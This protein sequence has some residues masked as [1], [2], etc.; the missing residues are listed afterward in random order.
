MVSLVS[1]GDPYK[2][3]LLNKKGLNQ[4]VSVQILTDQ[5]KL[6]KDRHEMI[7]ENAGTVIGVAVAVATLALFIIGTIVAPYLST[8]EFTYLM[9]SATIVPWLLAGAAAGGITY[10][11]GMLIRNYK[12]DKISKL[13]L[14]LQNTYEKDAQ[15]EK[16][17]IIAMLKKCYDVQKIKLLNKMNFEQLLDAKLA[18]GNKK[19]NKFLDQKDAGGKKFILTKEEHQLIRFIQTLSPKDD[20]KKTFQKPSALVDHY[21]HTSPLFV[22]A[23]KKQLAGVDLKPILK[24][25]SLEDDDDTTIT[26]SIT[27]GNS[28]ETSRE[29][30]IQ[31]SDFFKKLLTGSFS[32]KDADVVEIEDDSVAFQLFIK[33]ITDE[34]QEITE[35]NVAELFEMAT[36]YQAKNLICQIDDFLSKNFSRIEENDLWK[37]LKRCP[38]LKMLSKK[39]HNNLLNTKLNDDNFNRFWKI[40]Q[41][42]KIAELGKKCKEYVTNRIVK[43]PLPD[44]KR[45]IKQYYKMF[46]DSEFSDFVTT[47]AISFENIR[48]LYEFGSKK[49]EQLKTDCLTFI[50]ENKDDFWAYEIWG[51]NDIPNEVSEALTKE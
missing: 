2:D 30:L 26:I 21:L 28:I 25:D 3:P 17:E 9:L 34:D 49:H 45:W 47:L 32:E 43:Y 14:Y 18:L 15:M 39:L 40:A 41:K 48:V 37:F 33:F 16:D 1:S 6:S 10:G 5:V 50:E 38:D 22:K 31:A 8:L 20:L 46:S 29:K 11:I 51:A 7:A 23:I 27:D 24:I 13:I 36:K 19:F 44:Y 35:E 42:R 12:T 4:D